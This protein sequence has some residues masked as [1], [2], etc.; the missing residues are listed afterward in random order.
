MN[1]LRP[2]SLEADSEAA[3]LKKY[4]DTGRMLRIG[5]WVLLLGFGGFIAWASFAPI[6]QGVPAVGT[7]SVDTKRKAV[8]HLY[9]GIVA[10]VLVREGQEVATGEPLMRLDDNAL[11]ADL[12]AVRQQV[13][14]LR[15]SEARLLAE[16]AGQSEIEFEQDLLQVG[17]V[18]PQTLRQMNNE[19]R[20]LQSR[21][22]SLNAQIIG[23][24]ETIKS[25]EAMIISTQNI[26]E[27]LA[28]QVISI[29]KE[30][31]GIRT[32]VREGYLPQITQLE[33]ER[34]IAAIRNQISDNAALEIRAQQ[35]ILGLKQQ[36]ITVQADNDKGLEQT[37]AQV[38]P[39][40]QALTERLRALNETQARLIIRSPST[41]A[42]RSLSSPLTPSTKAAAI[43]ESV[44][45][46]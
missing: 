9:G 1:L 24:R 8:Q 16:L 27:N 7:V 32:M 18:D 28:A 11:R 42:T 2:T 6:E 29:E 14:G 25:H 20:L 33:K 44:W 40:L 35:S 17:A 31:I 5:V 41:V 39:E 37:L 13:F 46:I 3:E 23:L 21:Q 36:V 4:A 45:V 34:Q 38:R 15:V 12:E 19:G 30:L 26:Q 43:S 22:R 10:K